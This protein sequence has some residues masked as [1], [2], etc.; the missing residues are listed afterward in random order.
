MKTPIAACLLGTM[1]LTTPTFAADLTETEVKQLALEAIMENPQI[2]MDAVELLR[3]REEADKAAAATVALNDNKDTIFNDENAV[4]LGNPDGDVTV[5]EFFD[6]NCGY[7]KRAAGGVQAMIAA[8]PNLRVVMR[9]WPILSEGSVV[10]SRAALAARKQGLYE[11]LHWALMDLPRSD[12]AAVMNVAAQV[13]LDIEQ[14]KADMQAPEVEEHIATS[15]N[16]ANLLGFTGT[17]SFIAGDTMVP[18]YV[19]Q[20]ELEQMVA[21]FRAK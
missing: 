18:G 19:P 5:V 8:D 10:A 6:Y 16:L 9:E 20:E 3:Q 17:P 11:P 7:C 1:C 4:I 21:Q 14:L 15:R 13:G 12:E 2:I